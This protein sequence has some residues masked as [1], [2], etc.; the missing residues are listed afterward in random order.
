L[1]MGAEVEVLRLIF[2]RRIA[3][4][5]EWPSSCCSSATLTTRVGRPCRSCQELHVSLLAHVHGG[6]RPGQ[7][8]G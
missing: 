8:C 3:S 7:I 6:L 4:M 5:A 1:S 2:A